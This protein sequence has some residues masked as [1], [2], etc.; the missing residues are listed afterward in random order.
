MVLNF[1]IMKKLYILFLLIG[2][3]SCSN[4][5]I[6]SDTEEQFSTEEF[7]SKDFFCGIGYHLEF[8]VFDELRL[9][10]KGGCDD[11]FGFCFGIRLN[12]V[13][14]CVRNSVTST[15]N[16]Q[17]VFY[18]SQT[19]YAKS[20][21]IANPIAKEITFYFH[22]DITNSPNHNPS[23]FDILDVEDGVSLKDDVILVGG[24][25]SKSI[26]SNDYFKYVVPYTE[27]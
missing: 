19:Q 20:L 13:F 15:P 1:K 21:A 4:D 27:K 25:Y 11:G 12:V 6:D 2:L 23:D 22:K 9:F 5:K 17:N 7:E 3:F 10:K 18:D 14:D 8:Q 24:T 16:N 26:F